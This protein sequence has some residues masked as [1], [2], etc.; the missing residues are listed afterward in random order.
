[1]TPVRHP[2]VR[3]RLYLEHVKAHIKTLV[4]IGV[5]DNWGGRPPIFLAFFSRGRKFYSAAGRAAAGVNVEPE[6]TGCGA[7]NVGARE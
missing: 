1:M 2:N 6:N 3:T 5:V 4:N 7:Q